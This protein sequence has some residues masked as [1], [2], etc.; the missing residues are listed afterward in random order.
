MASANANKRVLAV[1]LIIVAPP[2]MV[3]TCACKRTSKGI[4]PENGYQRQPYPQFSVID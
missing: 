2:F 1:D 4:V 3:A